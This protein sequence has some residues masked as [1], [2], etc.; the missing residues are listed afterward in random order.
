MKGVWVGVG[1]GL[2]VWCGLVFGVRGRVWEGIS[3]FCAWVNV[4]GCEC[5]CV[6]NGECGRV[7]VCANGWVW[8]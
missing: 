3:V 5:M 1:Y 2:V 4:G 7:W 8:V 6:C